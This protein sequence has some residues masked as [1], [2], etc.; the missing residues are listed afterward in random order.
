MILLVTEPSV[1]NI[2]QTSRQL[3]MMRTQGLGDKAVKVVL[4]RYK[5]GLFK[6]VDVSACEA[7]LGRKI[8]QVIPNNYVLMSAAL[9]RG[10]PLSEVQ[11]R[12]ALEK[13]INQLADAVTQ[14]A[15]RQAV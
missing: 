5:K 8:D 7:G 10:L 15:L 4:N 13:A 14:D 3:T 2:R 6:P 11:G 12:S 9:N 1:G